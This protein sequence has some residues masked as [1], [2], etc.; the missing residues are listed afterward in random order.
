VNVELRD[1]FKPGPAWVGID[2]GQRT[3]GL[4]RIE[5]AA[6]GAWRPTLALARAPNPAVADCLAN[7]RGLAGVGIETASCY[8]L[9]VGASVFETV[10]W[11]GRFAQA[12]FACTENVFLVTRAQ[13]KRALCPGE[14]ANDVA[15]R[16]RLL[17]MFGPV[18][19][20]GSH[21]W[22]ALAVAFVC[23]TGNI[24]VRAEKPGYAPVPGRVVR[25]RAAA[26]S[27]WRI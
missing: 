17:S 16:Q 21:A 23:A 13:V 11:A 1:L 18:K 2:P 10:L 20:V 26:L 5:P 14:R 15:V 4:C 19:G 24:A 6:K 12:A 9:P 27:Q 7:A 8:G 25:A 22:A 3:S